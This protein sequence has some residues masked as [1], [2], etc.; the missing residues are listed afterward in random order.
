MRR[1]EVTFLPDEWEVIENS[2]KELQI[3]T[4]EYIRRMSLEGTVVAYDFSALVP[5][6]DRLNT[7]SG[8]INQMHA[9]AHKSKKINDDS[10]VRM[11]CEIDQIRH[12]LM[13][14]ISELRNKKSN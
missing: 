8:K 5:I 10:L 3:P 4:A 9:I 14:F 2:S 12:M 13:T 7:I 11:E 6:I 1:K